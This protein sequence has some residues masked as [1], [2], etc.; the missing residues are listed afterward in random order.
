[1]FI[2]GD[3]KLCI[4]NFRIKSKLK[5]KYFKDRNRGSLA[6]SYGATR[7]ICVVII[8]NENALFTHY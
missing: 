4:Q 5:M 2:Q 7:E 1:M 3:E 6:P 8:K